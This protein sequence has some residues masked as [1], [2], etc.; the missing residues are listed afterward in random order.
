[1]GTTALFAELLVGGILTLTW[2]ALLAMTFLGPSR[3]T[4]LL[5]GSPL[6]TGLFLALAY[7]LGVVFDRVWDALLDVKG[8]QGWLRHRTGPSEKVRAAEELRR[9]VF[10]KDA[11]IAA[12]FVNYHRSRMRVARASL[13]NFA[14]ITV[15]GMALLAVR[16]GGIGTAEFT[17]AGV[18]GGLLCS[19]S[20]LAFYELARNYE[21]VLEIS[22]P[23]KDNSQ[24]SSSTT[25]ERSAAPDRGGTPDS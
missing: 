10:G 21:R 18:A 5:A 6:T 13:F 4:P 15:S 25:V 19:A 16:F 11:K 20:A 1:M 2:I 14:L 8:F 7:A 12:E 23:V 9:N 3:V 17:L 24:P 22:S